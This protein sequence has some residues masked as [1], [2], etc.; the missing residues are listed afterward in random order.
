MRN[1]LSAAGSKDTEE[2]AT[3]RQSLL[4][5]PW[6]QVRAYFLLPATFKK[7][8]SVSPWYGTL[9]PRAETFIIS[10]HILL[11]VI[12]CA[13]SYT[14]FP[15]NLDWNSKATQIWRYFSDRT[16]YLSYANVTVFFVFGIRNNILIW[17]T[18]WNFSTFNRFHR[19]V[20]RIATLEAVLH[21]IAYTVFD[22]QDGG[23]ASYIQDFAR[24]YWWVGKRVVFR[25]SANSTQVVRYHRDHYDVLHNWIFGAMGPSEILRLLLDNTYSSSARH[26]RHSLLPYR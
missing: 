9:P 26:A 7:R 4:A 1:Y 10:V 25:A 17:L 2:S 15:R 23:F 19:W 18:G 24:R 8:C 13:V 14:A 3:N 22:F 20:A 5:R 21:S 6:N 16:G 11:N 12:L